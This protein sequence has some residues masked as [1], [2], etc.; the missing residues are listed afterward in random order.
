MTL[1]R[2]KATRIFYSQAGTLSDQ[3]ELL[4]N[5]T[6][7]NFTPVFNAVAD[8]IYI[9]RFHKFN[10]L[11][12]ALARSST[13]S[14]VMTA[15]YWN[16]KAWVAFTDF[17]DETEGLK[18]SGFLTW[19]EKDEWV[20]AKPADITGLTSMASN[21]ELYWI[22]VTLSASPSVGTSIRSI[23]KI[24]SDDRLMATI[25]P[26]ILNF[27]P[28]DQEDFLPQHE[29][30]KDTIVN[31]LI[32]SGTISYEDQIKNPE[33][34]LLAASYKCAELVLA[35]IAGDERLIGVKDIMAANYKAALRKSSA[36]LDTDKNE[37]LDEKE[38]EPG[39][40]THLRR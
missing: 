12:V 26:E 1:L 23:K 30:A 32:M 11:Y 3:T 15:Q 21:Q 37:V 16:G 38:K 6:T 35:P 40:V 5:W 17:L 14:S 9:G 18:A 29:L 33:N 31:D 34:Y 24:L 27:L 39:F 22:K 4:R 13:V 20:K 7:P 19:E 25:H 28:E 8:A 2:S 36:D 10:Y